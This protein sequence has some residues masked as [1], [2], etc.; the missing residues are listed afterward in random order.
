MC[1]NPYLKVVNSERVWIPCG[2]C[3]QCIRKRKLDWELRLSRACAAS[4]CAF[5]SLLSFDPEHYP[6]D[7]HDLDN[8]HLLVKRF[9]ARLRKRLENWYSKDVKLK[10]Y[11]ATEYGEEK[12]R[13]H[14][15]V[16]FFLKGCHFTWLEWSSILHDYEIY[17][18][19]TG[20]ST[21][22]R[23][24]P[25]AS[26][27]DSVYKNRYRKVVNRYKIIPPT[28]GF[29][30]IGNS[31]NLKVSPNR[32]GY[33]V[34]YIQKQYNKSWF[35]R[36]SFDDI[37]SDADVDDIINHYDYEDMKSLPT[38]AYRGKRVPVPRSWLVKMMD[39]R[40][41]LEVRCH[42][43]YIRSTETEDEYYRRVEKEHFRQYLFENQ[44][45]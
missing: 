10:Y 14:F 23:I 29:G 25:D 28:W 4:D 9:I 13:L 44:N 33:T 11:V 16:C 38:I 17:D 18:K 42:S 43:V 2:K 12:D 24:K 1:I 36:F 37:V 8:L 5:F 41:L 20:I 30:Y 45:T 31:Y 27:Y 34:K 32:I 21:R 7:D 3:Y 26:F 6:E 15:H 39:W 40:E 19:V 22:Q 35:S